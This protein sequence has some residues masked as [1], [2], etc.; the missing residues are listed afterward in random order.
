RFGR[1]AEARPGLRVRAHL[2][3][4]G[5]VRVRWTGTP[6]V[7]ATEGVDGAGVCAGIE[8]AS[9]FAE[10]DPY[11]A[12]THNKGIMNGIDPVVI[13]TG[14]DW[15]AVEAAA[16]AFAARRGRYEPLCCWR[17]TPDGRL[18]GRME[19]PLALGTVGGT[20]RVHS[21]ARL[22]MKITGVGS[23]QEL[24][25]LAA[26]AGMASNLAALRALA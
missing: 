19:L 24:A 6:D 9:R 16:H 3:D 11:R 25:M 26:C 12:A 21:G 1:L 14:N 2:C 23:A 22:A 10:R 8:R 5:C 7:L 4:H 13:A 18:E 15:R 17:R 20:L